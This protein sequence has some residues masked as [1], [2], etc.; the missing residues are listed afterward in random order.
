MHLRTVYSP[1][2]SDT[3]VR[4]WQVTSGLPHAPHWN[5]LDLFPSGCPQKRVIFQLRE[6][7][8]PVTGSSAFRP[9]H[10]SNPRLLQCR[11]RG[12]SS[13]SSAASPSSHV[14]MI[15]CLHKG[16][17][18]RDDKTFPQRYNSPGSHT[19]GVSTRCK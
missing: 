11:E 15:N 12:L 7:F 2:Y 9:V 19:A 14:I 6:V 10:D 8:R 1:H 5:V 18:Q 4:T 13:P 3:R 16:K 17:V